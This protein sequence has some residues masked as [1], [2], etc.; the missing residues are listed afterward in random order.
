MF[1]SISEKCRTFNKKYS[2]AYYEYTKTGQKYDKTLWYY[3]PSINSVIFTEVDASGAVIGPPP[4]TLVE[5]GYV[6]ESTEGD[7]GDTGD[8]GS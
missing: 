6:Y 3:E 5:I 1:Q 7:T 8:T 2:E 4:S